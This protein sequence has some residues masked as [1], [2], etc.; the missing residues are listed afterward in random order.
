MLSL[1]LVV[2][3]LAALAMIQLIG[4]WIVRRNRQ[5]RDA[6]LK[7]WIH[8]QDKRPRVVYR[9]VQIQLAQQRESD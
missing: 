9:K 6:A 2:V 1:K 5:K 7:I 4:E 8:T 3:G